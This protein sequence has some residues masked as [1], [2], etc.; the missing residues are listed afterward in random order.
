VGAGGFFGSRFVECAVL[1]GW[2]DVVPVVRRVASLPG[3]SRFRVPW[4]IADAADVQKLAQ[5]CA[6]C[7]ALVHAVVGDPPVIEAAARALMPAA[8]QAGVKRVIFLSSA[9]VHGQNPASGTTEDAA[10][11]DRQPIA[12]NNAKV[13]AERILQRDRSPNGPELVIL[14]PGIVFGPRDRWVTSMATE[15]RNG[16]ACVGAEGK[17]ICN[18]IYVDNLVSAVR[19]AMCSDG[20]DGEAFFVGDPT[21]MTWGWFYRSVARGLLIDAGRIQYVGATPAPKR[22]WLSELRSSAAVQNLLPYIPSTIKRL[23]KALVRELSRPPELSPF[24]LPSP[25]S[26]GLSF[27]LSQLHNCHYRLP[28]E[29][30]ARLLGYQPSISCETGLERTVAWLKWCDN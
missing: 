23:G 25:Q 12:Y 28:C 3:I 6:G 10:L 5:A 30:A 8:K 21:A 27:E 20:V 14:R 2:A 9:S 18:S 19:C 17:G 1:G 22:R 4:R 24:A 16:R 15:L 26:S 13:R 29:K 11:S 7:D